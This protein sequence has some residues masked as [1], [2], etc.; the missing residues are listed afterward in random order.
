MRSVSAL[1]KSLSALSSALPT[2]LQ[3]APPG[4]LGF[5]SDPLHLL[6][7]AAEEVLGETTIFDVIAVSLCDVLGCVRVFCGVWPLTPFFDARMECLRTLKLCPAVWVAPR[8]LFWGHS[9]HMA[10][11]LVLPA[12]TCLV[13]QRHPATPVALRAGWNF[14]S[15]IVTGLRGVAAIQHGGWLP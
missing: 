14:S 2:V 7:S 10:C 13:V 3:S 15:I 11:S 8:H 9:P 4:I 1:H 5:P 12:L 6:E